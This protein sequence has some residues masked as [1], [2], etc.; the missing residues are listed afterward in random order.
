ML[1]VEC[2]VRGTVESY[3]Q[4]VHTQH[5]QNPRLLETKSSILRSFAI[6]HYAS[7]VQY[8]ATDFLG[9]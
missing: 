3:I 8:D 5:K 4:K 6:Q 2:S 7:K 1:D 9:K